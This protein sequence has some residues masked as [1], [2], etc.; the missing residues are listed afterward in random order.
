MSSGAAVERGLLLAHDYN[1]ATDSEYH[2]L[3]NLA[4]QAYSQRKKLSHESQIAYKK[5]QKAKAHELSEEAKRQQTKAE[6]FNLQ[7]AEYVFVQ[8]NADSASDEIDLHGL[9][10]KEA[11]WVLK[12]RIAAAIQQGEPRLKVI[13]GKGLHSID[14]IAKIKPAVE[15]L[16]DEANLRN[17][18]D[19]KN[20][21]LLIIELQGS[22]VPQSWSNPDVTGYHLIQP[23]SPTHPVSPI[24]QGPQQPQYYSQQQQQNQQQQQYYPQQQQQQQQQES[25]GNLLVQ[26]LSLLC[27]CL[28]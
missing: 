20:A 10:V 24:Y 21:G 8:N 22:N 14:G 17:Y 1:H 23:P 11:E 18:V 15:G 4:D 3:R 13:V 19:P 16:C 5:G 2:R 27:I 9:Y 6:N 12:R 7:A 25:G 28:S 26:M